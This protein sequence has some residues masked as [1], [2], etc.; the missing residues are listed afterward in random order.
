MQR[1]FNTLLFYDSR[2]NGIKTGHV[3]EA[4]YHLVASA[5]AGDLEFGFGRD[6]HAEHGKA[7]SRDRQAARLGVSHLHDRQVDWHKAAPS[8]S[9]VYQGDIEEVPI[10]P[11]GG[12]P[13]FTVGQGD[14]NKVALTA[15]IPQKPLIAPVKKGTQSGQ[16]TVT[17]AGKPVSTVPLVNAAGGQQGG[18]V[19]R[20][21]DAIRLKL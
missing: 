6:G 2:V 10:A 8:R 1:N 12:T 14:E 18:M 4:G 17:I 16:L 7:A 11:A 9:A 13:Y 5:H 15:N 20:M 19:H 3:E 21:V